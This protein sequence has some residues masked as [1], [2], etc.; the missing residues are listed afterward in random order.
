MWAG[1]IVNQ[2]GSWNVNLCKINQSDSGITFKKFKHKFHLYILQLPTVVSVQLV[3]TLPD[4]NPAGVI[5]LYSTC[6]TSP[7]L[8]CVHGC[9]VCGESAWSL[10]QS[11]SFPVTFLP[12]H[13]HSF[14]LPSS[15]HSHTLVH[16]VFVLKKNNSYYLQLGY[17]LLLHLCQVVKNLDWE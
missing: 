14:S 5:W 12:S 1:R 7:L 3:F 16:P 15:S 17:G 9:S 10:W 2:S 6:S 11:S 8:Q 13:M 4:L